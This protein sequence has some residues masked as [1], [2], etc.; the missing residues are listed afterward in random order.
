M[1]GVGTVIESIQEYCTFGE[2]NAYVLMA[3]ARRKHNEEISNSDEVIYRRVLTSE[4]GV[5]RNVRDVLALMDRHDLTFRLYLTVN[6]RDTLDA[7]FQ[8]RTKMNG[9]IQDHV[10]GDVNAQPKFGE[11]DSYWKS[12]VHKPESQDESLFLFDLDGVTAEEK[13]EFVMT[14]P[15]FVFSEVQTPNGYHV[16]T[17]PFNYTGW[18]PPV[19]YD[20]LQTDGQ[21]FVGEY[22]G[23][24]LRGPEVTR[25]D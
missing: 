11:I 14:C 15:R 10:N 6:A 2:F 20:D 25:Y 24:T 17:A 7:Y 5:E 9:W 23:A 8:F 13:E 4:D 1:T 18:E 16:I 21:L 3:I 19:E 12:T 22:D